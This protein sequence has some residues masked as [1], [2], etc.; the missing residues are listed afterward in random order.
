MKLTVLVDNNTLIDRYFIAEPGLSFLIQDEDATILF[1]TGYSGVFLDNAQKM[2]LD[3]ANLDYLVLSHSHLDHTWGI[4]RLL[5]YYT[6][7]AIEK[8][9]FKKPKLVTHPQ[10]FTSV[11]T[12]ELDQIGSLLS[13]DKLDKHFTMQLNKKPLRLSERLIFLGE[14]PRENDFEAIDT[15]GRKEGAEEGDRVIEDSA[16]VYHSDRGLVIITGCSH[17]GICNIVEYAKQ[18]CANDKIAE[19]IGGLHLQSSSLQQLQGTLD[20]MEQLQPNVVRACHCTDL[21]SKI[22]LSS[23]VNIKEVGVGLSVEY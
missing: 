6:E 15:I 20:Y 5:K 11:R 16:L 23:V 7:L 10:T 14:I 12:D 22:A 17:A 8:R 2:G 21:D 18:V 13:V 3:L 1:D 19:I 9:P 4:D